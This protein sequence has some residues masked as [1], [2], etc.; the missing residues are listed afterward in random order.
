[1]RFLFTLGYYEWTGPAEPMAE[2]AQDLADLGHE[3]TCWIEGDR[4]GDLLQR[5]QGHGLSVEQPLHLS[6]K[7]GPLKLWRD[8]RRVADLVEQQFDAVIAHMSVDAALLT[9]ARKRHGVPVIRYVQNFAGLRPRIGRGK[10]LRSHDGVMVPASQ[11]AMAVCQRFD[12]DPER[13]HIL[14]GAVDLER[15]RPDRQGDL[16]QRMGLGSGE[17]LLACVARMKPERQ[18]KDL[19]GALRLAADARPELRLALVGRGEFQPRLASIVDAC[20]VLRDR[21]F[22]AGYASGDMLPES[23]AD[24]D[25]TVWLAE[26]N[27]GTCRAVGQSLACGTP[28][29][30]ADI[31]AIHTAL[32]QN[33]KVG[34]LVPEAKPVA[35]AEA[36]IALPKRDHLL[37]MAPDCRAV[38]EAT[39]SRDQRCARFL[40]AVE[41]ILAR[42]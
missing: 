29:I 27:D 36:L 39:W 18:H 26:G 31:G 3:V 20:P 42:E 37:H 7:A 38:A 15:F 6:R 16:R 28:V 8:A 2:L 9:S 21:V 23:I 32:A 13:V 22:F 5:L 10:L 40:T 4:E 1:M 34:W 24:A 12:V 11:H 41:H 25:A 14:P 30:G 19:L 35:L 17:L 33:L